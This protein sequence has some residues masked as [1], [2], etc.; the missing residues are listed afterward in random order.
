MFLTAQI[1]RSF[2]L[3]LALGTFWSAAGT[4][5]G[6]GLTRA[7]ALKIAETF[8]QHR[9]PASARNVRHGKDSDGVEIHTPDHAGG[10]G[11][12]VEDC[13]RSDAE[14]TG[15]AYKWGG[16]DTPAAFNAGVRA[17]KAAGDV[18]SQDKRRKGGAAVSGDAV[19]I[20]CSGFVSRC[21]K[22]PKKH[23][24]A[25]LAS[26]SKRLSSAEELR[27]GDVMNTANGHVLLFVRWLDADKKRALFY[28]AAPFS[29]TRATQRALDEL[30]S[31]AYEPLRYRHISD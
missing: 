12:P 30:V 11:N 5:A 22:L 21:W 8:V 4:A 27:A 6:Q 3:L 19:G 9:W 18:Y 1:R 17:G 20:D 23:S 26:I 13:W 16:F 2:C 25:T 7:E 29:K 31:G 24:T 10:K 28:E 14:N 15:V